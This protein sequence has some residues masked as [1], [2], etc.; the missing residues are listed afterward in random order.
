MSAR[1]ILE[2]TIKSAAASAEVMKEIK[3][4]EK[5]FQFKT[6]EG[7]NFYVRISGGT[8]E[9]LGGMA[10]KA[11]TTIAGSDQTL[12]DLLSGKLDPVKAFMSG[13]IKVSGDVFA[14]QKITSLM[15]KAGA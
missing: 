15:K 5:T 9:V 12:S 7:E 14:A 11:S 13:Q 10:E 8:A 4:M 6:N 3:G 1:E 2:R